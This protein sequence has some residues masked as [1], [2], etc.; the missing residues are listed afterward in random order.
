MCS[1]ISAALITCARNAIHIKLETFWTF[2]GVSRVCINTLF[3]T[4]ISIFF[5][6][7]DVFKKEKLVW[8]M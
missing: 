1:N 7:I 5:A 3:F 4:V 8:Y 6:L 2:A